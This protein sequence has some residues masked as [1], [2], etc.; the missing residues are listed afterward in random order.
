[1]KRQL[2]LAFC[3]LCCLLVLLARCDAAY[4]PGQQD[5]AFPQVISA[6]QFEILAAEKIEA[7]FEAGGDERRHELKLMRSTNSMRL[8]AGE[9]TCETKLPKG[10]RYT[11]NTPVEMSVFLDG[12]FY[13]RVVCYYR[14]AVYEPVLVAAKDIKLEQVF[15][16]A[17][18]RVEEREVKDNSSAYAHSLEDVKGRVPSR[19]IKAG[20][21]I[22][23][24]YLQ[25]PLVFESGAPVTLVVRQGGIQVKA[26][27]IA[28]QKGRIGKVIRVR[29]LV[30]GKVLRAK[31]IDATTVEI[32]A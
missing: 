20:Q 16:Q 10:L 6:E 4:G 27:G 9:V 31:V 14:V 19:I 32:V 21:E 24:D 18:V 22:R 5:E 30:S 12:K 29:N 26:E 28:M 11:G 25:S 8:P 1:M 15:T 13:R 2:W 17:D 23:M 7:M 3:T